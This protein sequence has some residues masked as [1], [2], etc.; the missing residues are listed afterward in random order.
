LSDGN[1]VYFARGLLAMVKDTIFDDDAICN[2]GQGHRLAGQ[3]ETTNPVKLYPNPA[4]D[5]LT[6]EFEE[7][8]ETGHEITIYSVTGQQQ[9]RYLLQRGELSFTLDIS[10]VPAGMYFYKISHKGRSLQNGKLMIMKL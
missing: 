6:V 4:P 2:A 9:A 10:R 3:G 5:Q 7:S 8:L 1:A